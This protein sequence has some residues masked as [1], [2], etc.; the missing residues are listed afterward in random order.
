MKTWTAWSILAYNLDTPAK[1]LLRSDPRMGEDEG[2]GRLGAFVPL[3]RFRGLSSRAD[4]PA[5]PTARR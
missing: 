5:R 3:S 4:E 1:R 2:K